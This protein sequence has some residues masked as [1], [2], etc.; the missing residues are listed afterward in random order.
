MT[1]ITSRTKAGTINERGLNKKLEEDFVY[2]LITS[3][4]NREIEKYKT[5]NYRTIKFINNG[6]FD[7]TFIYIS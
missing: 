6:K 5:I 4:Q 2:I 3:E 1:T 7:L